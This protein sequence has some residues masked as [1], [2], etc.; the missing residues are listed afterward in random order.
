MSILFFILFSIIALYVF[1][2]AAA[3]VVSLLVIRHKLIEHQEKLR[4]G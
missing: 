4:F 3:V 1:C 2:F